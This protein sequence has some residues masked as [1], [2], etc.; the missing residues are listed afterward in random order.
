MMTKKNIT[1][2][3][4]EANDDK[5]WYRHFFYPVQAVTAPI[6]LWVHSHQRKSWLRLSRT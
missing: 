6:S 2:L 4:K 1:I 5:D 3:A